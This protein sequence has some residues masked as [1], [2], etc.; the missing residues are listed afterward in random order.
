MHIF[1]IAGAIA[2]T[3]IIFFTIPES[4]KYHYANKRFDE[5]RKILK[6]VAKW[7]K[8]REISIED[9]DKIVFDTEVNYNND[10]E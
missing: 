3:I 8:K 6:F 4:P 1:G 5:T 9:I 2:I 7:N 10:N